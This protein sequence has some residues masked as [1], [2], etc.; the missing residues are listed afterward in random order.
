MAL[1][2]SSDTDALKKV[3]ILFNVP[4]GKGDTFRQEV[5]LQFAPKV[6]SDSRKGNWDEKD[7]FGGFEPLAIYRGSSGRNI[8]LQITYINDGDKWNCSTI[9]Q[10]VNL[11]RGYFMR[12]AGASMQGDALV[13]KLSLWCIGGNDLMTFRMRS[14]DVKYSETMVSD[15]TPTIIGLY[16]YYPLR[17]DITIDLS[18]WTKKTAVEQQA[19]IAQ[20]AAGQGATAPATPQI[21]VIP[22]VPG[23]GQPPK[24]QPIIQD[25]INLRDYMP[26]DWY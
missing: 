4:N 25:I 22:G 16:S 3:T 23:Q 20:E 24:D 7:I 9:R 8:T 19:R 26:E 11:I 18:S 6:V 21:P 17:T 10:Q 1:R 2:T 14:C 15:S 13:V 12:A 5:K